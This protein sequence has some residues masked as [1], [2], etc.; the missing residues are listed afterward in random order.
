VALLT[1]KL[2]SPPLEVISSASSFLA[3]LIRNIDYAKYFESFTLLNEMAN[4][5]L[6]KIFDEKIQKLKY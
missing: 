3:L 1:P 2:I 4:T 6:E 5:Q